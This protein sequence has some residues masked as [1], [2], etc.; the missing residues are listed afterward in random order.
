MLLGIALYLSGRFFLVGVALALAV[1][2]ARLALPLLRQ[3]S[4]VLTD[5]VVGERRGRALAG[6]LGLAAAVGALLFAL[7]LPLHTRAQGV[8]WL[9]ERCQ[10][11]A[12]A[13]G[14]V[15]EVLVEPHSSVHAGEPL[16]RTRDAPTEAR[17]QALEAE[18][19]E[20]RLRV[21]A[22]SQ[23]N[24][25][26]TEIAQERLAHSEAA[27]ARAREQAGEVLI[28][29]P[30]DGVFVLAGGEDLVGRLVAQGE[31][32]GYVVDLAAATARVVVSQEEV[33]LLRERAEAAWVRLAHDIG[34]VLPARISREVPAATDRL[35]TRALGTAGGGRF[36]VDPAD[37][38]GLR[39]TERIFQFDLSL[40]EDAAIPVAG[41][42]VYVRFDHGAEPLAQ[43][44]YRALRRLFLR[45]LGV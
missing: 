10:V 17:V 3:L 23:E 39:T 8:I 31:V 9:P 6:S 1:L 16:I 12:G 19:R 45:Q 38:D 15:T 5:P 28:R 20:L 11:R 44:G 33:A 32:V 18:R 4:F 14:F 42:R 21:L 37:P 29:S 13:E 43:R 36:A 41:G 27:L 2:G 25:V 35:P 30:T 40:P 24:R 26:Q 22:L 34:T 7:P